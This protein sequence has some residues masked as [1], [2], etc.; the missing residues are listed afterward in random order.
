MGASFKGMALRHILSYRLTMHGWPSLRGIVGRTYKG[1]DGRH[2]SGR[3]PQCF[4]R[5]VEIKCVEKRHFIH[6]RQ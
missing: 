2:T 4:N 3:I 1:F 5:L 6:K